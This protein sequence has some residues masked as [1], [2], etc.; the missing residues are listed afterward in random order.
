MNVEEWNEQRE[1]SHRIVAFGSS[2]T[3]L[4]YSNA[5]RHNWVDWLYIN[6][7][8]HIGNHVT[9]INHGIGGETTENLLDRVDR[10]VR[11]LSPSIVIITIGGNDANLRMP[12]SQYAERLREL[13]AIIDRYGAQPVLQTYYCPLYHQMEQG[14]RQRFETNMGVK[15]DLAAELAL[16]LVDQY[17]FFEPFYSS[18]PDDYARLMRDPLHVNHLGNLAMGQYISHCLSLPAIPVPE[19]MAAEFDPLYERMKELCGFMK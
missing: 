14:Y 1:V 17:A 5:G 9:V 16:P 11:P 6:L 12:V 18:H 7:R 2:N 13:C 3:E 10:D 8:Q 15:R 4:S 19:D